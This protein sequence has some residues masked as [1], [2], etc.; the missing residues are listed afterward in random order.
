MLCG[1]VAACIHAL[2]LQA[3][4]EKLHPRPVPKRVMHLEDVLYRNGLRFVRPN[5]QTVVGAFNLGLQT[6]AA[7]AGVQSKN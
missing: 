1:P 4:R 5:S 6:P 7:S 3:L 2:V